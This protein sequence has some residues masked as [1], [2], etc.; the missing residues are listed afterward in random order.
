[1]NNHKKIQVRIDEYS[2]G[3][4]L[5]VIDHDIYGNAVTIID[6]F[7]K[8]KTFIDDGNFMYRELEVTE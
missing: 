1:M 5:D 8:T 2:Y 7:N 6:N 3:T 4:W